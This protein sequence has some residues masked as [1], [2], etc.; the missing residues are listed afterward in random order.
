MQ[1]CLKYIEETI[2]KQVRSTNGTRILVNL[3]G[4]ENPILYYTLWEKLSSFSKVNNVNLICKLSDDKY[5]EY[6]VKNENLQIMQKF[7]EHN[8]VANGEKLTKYRNMIFD[9]KT[10]IVLIGTQLTIDSNSLEDFFSIDLQYMDNAVGNRYHIVFKDKY[11]DIFDNIES[12]KAIDVIYK[13]I[14]NYVPKNIFQLSCIVDDLP[15][16]LQSI[17]EICDYIFFN[18]YKDWN[19]PNIIEKKPSIKNLVNCK[20]NITILKQ[21]SNFI[22]RKGYEKPSVVTKSCKQIDKYLD[23]VDKSTWSYSELFSGY[24]EF[25]ESLKSYVRGFNIDNNRDL[26]CKMDYSIIDAALGTKLSTGTTTRITTPKY[27]DAPLISISKAIIDFVSCKQEKLGERENLTL[28]IDIQKIQIADVIGEYEAKTVWNNVCKSAGGVIEYLNNFKFA[29]SYI[30]EIDIC[31]KNQDKFDAHN[32]SDLCEKGI[33]SVLGGTSKLSKVDFELSTDDD[34][35]SR[36]YQLIF[37]LKDSWVLDFS[38]INERLVNSFD[39]DS[40]IPFGLMNDMDELFE[41][42]NSSDF[43][44]LYNRKTVE[45]KENLVELFES[46]YKDFYQ[47]LFVKYY[48]LGERFVQWCKSIQSKGFYSTIMNNTA[49]ELISAYVDYGSYI[50]NQRVGDEIKSSY[51]LF[52]NAFMIGSSMSP[53][54]NDIEVDRIIATPF[55]PVTL[56]KLVE[57]SNY[58]VWGLFEI[59]G[60]LGKDRIKVEDLYQRIDHVNDLSQVDN[61]VDVL[62]TKNRRF[63][64]SYRSFGNY[65]LY[66]DTTNPIH[67]KNSRSDMLDRDFSVDESTK[68]NDYKAVTPMSKVLSNNIAEYV[69]TFPS[70]SQGIE[71]AVIN[72]QDFQPVISA[73]HNTIVGSN[74]KYIK[75]TIYMPILHQGG[76][77]YLSYWVNNFFDEDSDVTV[78]LYLKYYKEESEIENQISET[79]DIIFYSD[80]LQENSIQFS[81]KT[82]ENPITD[83]RYPLVYRALPTAVT[84]RKRS[85]EISQTQFRAATIH[86]QVI[87]NYVNEIYENDQNHIVIKELALGDSRSTLIED[88]HNKAKW[89]VCIGQ[90]LDKKLLTNRSF[91]QSYKIIGFTTGEGTYGEYNVTISARNSMIDDIKKKMRKKLK[92]LFHNWSE[93]EVNQAADYCLDQAKQ[94]DGISLLKALNPNDYDIHNFLAYLMT[95]EYLEGVKSQDTILSVLVPLDMYKH[96]FENTSYIISSESKSR[97]DFLELIIDEIGEDEENIKIVANIIECK[98]ADMNP[99]HVDKAMNQV[100]HGFDVLSKIF[101]KEFSSYEKKYWFSQLYRV[102]T[103]NEINMRDDTEDFPKISEKLMKILDGKFEITWSGSIM[104]YWVNSDECSVKIDEIETYNNMPI[105]QY[106]FG[107]IVIQELLSGKHK[108]ELKFDDTTS[109]E[110]NYAFDQEFDGYADEYDQDDVIIPDIPVEEVAVSQ[111]AFAAEEETQDNIKDSENKIEFTS[112]DVLSEEYIP[113][114]FV[115]EKDDSEEPKMDNHQEDISNVK[116]TLDH[117]SAINELENVRVLLGYNRMSNNKVYWSFGNRKMSNRHMLITGK[118]GQGKTYA[119]QGMML[120]LAQ[121]GIPVIIF[122]YTGGFVPEKMEDRVTAILGDKVKQ[123]IVPIDKLSVNPFKMQTM[124]VAGREIE[125][126]PMIVAQRLADIF[127][128]I[129]KFGEQ[130]ASAIYQACRNGLDKYKDKM[131]FSYFRQELEALGTSYAKSVLSKLMLFLDYD[132]FDFEREFNWSD[133]LYN[134]GEVTVFQLSFVQSKDMQIAITEMILWDMWYYTMKNGNEGKPFAVILDEAQ[135]LSFGDQAPTTKILTEGRKF[136][137]SGWFATQFLKGQLKEEEINRLQQAALRVYFKPSENE[138]QNMAVSIDPEKKDLSRWINALKRAE[139]GQCIV[140]GDGVYENITKKSSPISLQVPKMEDR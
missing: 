117:T 123:Q 19:L 102:L 49:N 120:E 52:T 27:Y 105:K 77:N 91:G 82:Y 108:T 109:L 116:E 95:S 138:I 12:R 59:F 56:E 66:A 37:S 62:L 101:D 119:I 118:S 26:L 8:L 104:T 63:I 15:E 67:S 42:K 106:S 38:D 84:S 85:V 35:I 83:T 65:V 114:R 112:N 89:I 129:Y 64:S 29:S 96:W 99:T 86:S 134:S 71:I 136:G 80:I 111:E 81:Q 76:R 39:M 6:S 17:D 73:L 45:Y 79:T 11:P 46:M 23:N 20:R 92:M 125:E 41:V 103:F 115:A 48:K 5:I 61:A 107:Q 60:D 72:F 93:E 22:A 34:Q 3:N 16:N 131:N 97:P 135:N 55:H 33:L 36:K 139:K 28:A 133:V 43:F 110:S 70:A 30:E 14:F 13:N 75:L 140:A 69:R 10:L 98:L 9:Q 1:F 24:E 126:L 124:T 51:K 113:E 130:Q 121:R 137:W 18:L 25:C 128:H 54:K 87:Y 74:I 58:I 47:D 31:W 4:F 44:D 53:V 94:L 78:K 57:K 132:V 7:S 68:L 127:V 32:T 88:L 100:K 2:E 50:R 90:G 122:D 40:Y 21:A